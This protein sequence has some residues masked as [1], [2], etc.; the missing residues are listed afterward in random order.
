[1]FEDEEEVIENK[2]SQWRRRTVVL[3]AQNKYLDPD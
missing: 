2:H 1:M 3:T